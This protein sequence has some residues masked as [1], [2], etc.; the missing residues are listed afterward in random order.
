MFYF[1]PTIALHIT[2]NF[3]LDAEAFQSLYRYFKM[4]G[5][6]KQWKLCQ[7]QMRF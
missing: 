1:S 5:Q 4:Y 7:E 6:N 3:N 2:I